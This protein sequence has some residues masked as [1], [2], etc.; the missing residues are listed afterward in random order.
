MSLCILQGSGPAVDR[1]QVLR[2]VTPSAL[3]TATSQPHYW[4][5]AEIRY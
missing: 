2:P 1:Q 4:D 5:P 3:Y